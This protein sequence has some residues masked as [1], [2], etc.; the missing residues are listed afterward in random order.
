MKEIHEFRIMEE[1]YHLLP[2][3]NNAKYNGVAY[4][5]K[6]GKNDP[7][8][9]KI[10][11]L[12]E[13]VRKEY[14]DFF[15]LFSNIKREY[16][17]KELDLATLL[18]MKI[19]TAFEPDGDQCGTEYD[20]TAACEICGT[21]RKQIGVLKLKKG[22][23]P[24]KDIARTIAGEVVVS[25]KF[26]EA[27]KKRGLKGILLEP[28]LFGK[29]ISNYCQLIASTEL[30]LSKNTIAG[31]NIFTTTTG[32]KGGTSYICGYKFVSEPEVYIC[33]KGDL[34]GLNLLSEAYVLNSPLIKEYDF[35]ASRQ[36]VGVKRGQ[37][38]PE[39]V[40]LCSPAFR[41][42]VIDEKLSGFD[43]EVAHIE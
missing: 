18:Q 34:I 38:R 27:V 2:Q 35:F 31:D 39:P 6:I 29:G 20:E 15:F 4:V 24:K 23:I 43:F 41:Q 30:E 33:P 12:K 7:N 25:E 16:S 5:L 28:V 10:K 17:K 37:L 14:D 21:N 36:K 32:S 42:M 9:E 19:K 8:F 40:Y 13:K 22:S 3:P 26:A 1:Y 11:F